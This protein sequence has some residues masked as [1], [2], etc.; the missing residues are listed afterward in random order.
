[1]IPHGKSSLQTIYAL[2]GGEA[3]RGKAQLARR[4]GVFCIVYDEKLPA[5]ARQCDIERA[6][7]CLR[8][9]R[10]SDDDFVARRQAQFGK[11]N[12]S[13]E[14]PPL[15]HQLDVQL[16]P[17]IIERINCIDQVLDD[18]GLAIKRHHHGVDG[19]FVVRERR[20]GNFR[21]ARNRGH[22][23][24]NECG[25]K[26]QPKRGGRNGLQNIES[27]NPEQASPRRNRSNR[28]NLPTGHSLP[29]SDY[30][31]QTTERNLEDRLAVAG[32]HE[33]GEPLRRGQG[34]R[35]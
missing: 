20:R 29:G 33:G 15:D 14:V 4:W 31:G 11:A 17:G 3:R 8:F 16:A 26:G 7:L 27:C 35:A 22:G 12:Q 5:C 23:S 6:R 24:Q 1:M 30:R 2:I 10:R 28:G 34:K 13:V 25:R 9:A 19:E 18:A 32:A 21:V